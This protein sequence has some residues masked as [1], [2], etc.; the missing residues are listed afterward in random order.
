MTSLTRVPPLAAVPEFEIVI[1]YVWLSSGRTDAFAAVLVAVM[2]AN[3]VVTVFEVKNPD[4][5]AGPAQF[6]NVYVHV[7]G[8]SYRAGNG[9]GG[10]PSTRSWHVASR[11]V[12]TA[13]S[14]I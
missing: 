7:G 14:P 10:I 2:R 13:T 3:S 12:L 8:T 4:C 9:A 1:V 11:R 6:T 5:G